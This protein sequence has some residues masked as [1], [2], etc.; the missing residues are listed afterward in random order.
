M[1][2]SERWSCSPHFACLRCGEVIA[3][4]RCDIDL[5]GAT[6]SV[7][8]QYL[9]LRSQLIVGP[10]NSR[11]GTRT[12]GLPATIVA[13]LRDHMA[14]YTGPDEY[15]LVFTSQL[16]GVRRRGNFR[17]DSGCAAA[18]AKLSVPGLHFHDLRHTAPGDLGEGALPG[19]AKGLEP[20][21][22]CLQNRTGCQEPSMVWADRFRRSTEIC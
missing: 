9:E 15:A 21:T 5:D 19:G 1:N 10:P 20:L 12:I 18:V 8:R 3:L 7:R 4:R 17:C 13:E 11:A 2:S 6:V 22:P 16:G 14:A